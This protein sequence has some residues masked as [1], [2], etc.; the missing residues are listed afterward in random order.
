MLEALRL[1]PTAR[2]VRTDMARYREVS[3]R[4]FSV[5]RDVEPHLEVFGLAACYADVSGRDE[6]PEAL[7]ERALAAVDAVLGLPLRVGIGAG[8][9]LARLAAEEVKGERGTVHVPAGGERAFL[10]PLPV[11]RLDGVGRK[12]ASALA[13]LGARTIAD[14]LALGRDRLQAEFGP[15][16]M[17]IH[18]CA[19]GEIEEP[20]RAVRHPKSL[21]RESTLRGDPPDVTVFAELL[22]GL[23]QQLEEELTR[24]GLAAGRVTVKVRFDHGTTTRSA[25]LPRPT[26]A[27]AELHP[28]AGRL[29][30]RTQAGAR[31]V[32]GL[33]IQ[34]SL[35]GP[36]GEADRQL[37]LFPST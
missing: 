18:A 10:D 29:L 7:A 17:R 27:A 25:T 32:R 36:A 24:L 8:K 12:T 15:H 21:S 2:A 6:A 26:A 22:A 37:D 35:L 34:L 1:C 13:A 23:A 30:D 33:G 3:R 28:V 14:V 16:G 20:V 9:F 31:P 4:L 19:A 11:A 5:L